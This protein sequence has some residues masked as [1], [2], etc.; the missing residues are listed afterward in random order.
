M[1]RPYTGFSLWWRCACIRVMHWEYW[2]FH[3][4][5][6][7]AF[8]YAGLLMLRARSFFYYNV[9]NPQIPNGG[10]LME[11]KKVIYDTLPQDLY[12]LT[13]LVTSGETM[14]DLIPRMKEIG[15][16]W[17]LI[18]KP[19]VGM[20][21]IQVAVLAGPEALSAYM[22]QMP[23]PFLLQEK[24]NF[25]EEAGIFWCRFPGEKEGRITGI[26]GKGFLAV[27][28]NGKDTVEKLLCYQPRGLLQLKALRRD[29][30]LQLA[31]VPAPGEQVEIVP[32]G[33]HSRGALF[34]DLSS[35][36]AASLQ[37]VM[38]EMCSRIPDFHF[39]RIDLRF[40]SWERLLSGKDYRIIEVNGSGSEPTHMYDP[41]HRIWFAWKEIMRHQRLLYRICKACRAHYR[42]PYMGLKAGLRLLR[43][44]KEHVQLLRHASR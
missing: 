5:Y 33:N 39:G 30:P 14:P 24:I 7:P 15:L 10:F 2:P 20:Q 42:I 31:A 25:P 9:A 12:P 28:G 27:T 26:V 13:L 11:S 40:Q 32:F 43:D 41:G 21:G 44:N 38:Q 17:P 8:A 4:L 19:D 1:T 29:M 35:R 36:Y 34:T 18:A 3:L 16:T 37:P 22:K 23:V 6:L